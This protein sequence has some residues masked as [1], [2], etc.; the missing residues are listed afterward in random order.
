MVFNTLFALWTTTFVAVFS[1]AIPPYF[2]PLSNNAWLFAE[3]VSNSKSI[4]F[5]VLFYDCI[6]VMYTSVHNKSPNKWLFH[7]FDSILKLI[8]P[9]Y[10]YVD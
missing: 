8:S 2:N 10:L 4:F 5:I 6:P 7:L 1:V 3:A 9:L